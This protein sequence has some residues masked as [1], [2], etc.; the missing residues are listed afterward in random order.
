MHLDSDETQLHAPSLPSA[1]HARE[2]LIGCKLNR[3]VQ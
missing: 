1:T 2:L 3:T